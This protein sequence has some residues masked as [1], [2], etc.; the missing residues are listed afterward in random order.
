MHGHLRGL[1]YQLRATPS[2]GSFTIL[3]CLYIICELLP[4][5]MDQ[6]YALDIDRHMMDMRS[7][8]NSG[9]DTVKG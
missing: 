7:K 1:L 3:T 9:V 6:N 5:Q 2:H 4:K 8:G